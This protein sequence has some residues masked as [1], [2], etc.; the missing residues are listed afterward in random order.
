MKNSSP[1]NLAVNCLHRIQSSQQRIE[2]LLSNYKSSSSQKLA[3]IKNDNELS[4]LKD[5]IQKRINKR[6]NEFSKKVYSFSPQE[7]SR[8][9]IRLRIKSTLR[10]IHAPKENPSISISTPK[11][12]QS[13]GRLY[14][15]Q[16]S[17]SRIPRPKKPQLTPNLPLI[18]TP[19]AISSK[20]PKFRLFK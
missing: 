11:I 15:R 6:Y 4:D 17:E 1:E 12:Q 8:H 16:H 5:Y 20:R 7:K 18:P 9:P 14:I 10:S 3:L 13:P 19:I 2:S